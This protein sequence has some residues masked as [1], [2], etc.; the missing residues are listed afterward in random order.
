M[1]PPCFVRPFAYQEG[2]TERDESMASAPKESIPATVAPLI[3]S[4]LLQRADK[5]RDE[6]GWELFRPGIHVRWLYRSAEGGPAAA[7]LRYQPGA[8]VPFHEHPGYEH[9][10]VLDGAQS[11]ERG[12]Y[13][14]GTLV[15][16][17]PLSR[18]CV[19]SEEGCVVLII[20]ERAIRALAEP[21][22]CPGSART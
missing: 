8:S 19:T 10:L 6:E 4:D 18:H 12:L 9:V 20:W 21:A 15:I 11:D 16:N 22:P 14:A 5:L 1:S 7:L 2:M 3:L 17:P 13:A